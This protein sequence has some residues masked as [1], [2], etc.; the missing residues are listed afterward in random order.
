ML[1]SLRSKNKLGSILATLNEINNDL[2][3]LSF[4]VDS[5]C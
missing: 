4:D 3:D 5:I 2:D 1:S